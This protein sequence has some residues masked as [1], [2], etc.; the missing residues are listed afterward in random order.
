MVQS[1]A[2][3]HSSYLS[4]ARHKNVSAEKVDSKDNHA[5]TVVD[6]EKDV[7]AIVNLY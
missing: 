1:S 5:E 6:A 3:E 7:T 2:E 4:L